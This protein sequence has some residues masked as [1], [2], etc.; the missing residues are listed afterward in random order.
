[1][2]QTPI[3]KRQFQQNP[4]QFEPAVAYFQLIEFKEFLGADENTLGLIH[5][6]DLMNSMNWE[7]LIHPADSVN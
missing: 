6:T 5:P 7:N 3:Q 4:P 1:M 2:W